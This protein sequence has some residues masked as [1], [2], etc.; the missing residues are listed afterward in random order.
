[1]DT[2]ARLIIRSPVGDYSRAFYHLAAAQVDAQSAVGEPA[3]GPQQAMRPV[4]APLA[5][6]R[7]GI[8]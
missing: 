8:V 4:S 7:P 3:A 6:R 1:M 5:A 2:P